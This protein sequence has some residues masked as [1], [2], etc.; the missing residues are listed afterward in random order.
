MSLREGIYKEKIRGPNTES[1]GTPYSMSDEMS[2]NLHTENG[3]CRID[4]TC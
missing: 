4:R 1:R 2:V 3:R